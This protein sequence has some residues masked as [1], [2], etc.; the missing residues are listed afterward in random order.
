VNEIPDLNTIDP[1]RLQLS[2]ERVGWKLVGGREDFYVRLRQN[3]QSLHSLLVPLNRNSPDFDDLLRGVV[4]DLSMNFPDTWIRNILPEITTVISDSVRFRKDTSAPVGMIGWRIGESLVASSGATLLAGAKT[5]LE[6]SRYFGNRHGRFASRYLEAI[7]MGQT[8]IGSYI[9]TAYVPTDARIPFRNS[10]EPSLE[11]E[12][13][14]GSTGRSITSSLSTALE[15][16]R[17]ALDSYKVHRSMRDFELGVEFGISH[18]LTKALASL[19][20]N[21]DGA[22][23]TIEWG[24]IAGQ[25][26]SPSTFEF[27]PSESVTLISASTILSSPPEIRSLLVAGRV[28]LL[29]KKDADG[30]GVVGVD[31][32]HRKYRVRLASESQYHDAVLAHDQKREIEVSGQLSKEGNVNWLYDATITRTLPIAIPIE[33]SPLFET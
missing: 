29:T 30:P 18:E 27:S 16:T 26:D 15:A 23:I 2:L 12:N 5:H 33:D 19:A 11:A 3:S 14:D 10:R 28:H 22:D 8:G 32:G 20:E 17:S 21:S 25:H 24:P 1:V 13:V 6:R 9:V 31:D 7:L 4:M